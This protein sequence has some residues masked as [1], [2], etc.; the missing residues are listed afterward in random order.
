MYPRWLCSLQ[1]IDPTHC[2]LCHSKI[3]WNQLKTPPVLFT[4]NHLLLDVSCPLLPRN[5]LGLHEFLGDNTLD[6]FYHC[7]Y[8]PPL[9]GNTSGLSVATHSQPESWTHCSY[10][11]LVCVVLEFGLCK[12]HGV[13]VCWVSSVVSRLFA[14][15]WTV[16]HQ[17]P[18]SMGFSR[19][20]YWIELPCPPPGDLP[21]PRIKPMSLVSPALAEWFFI[22]STTWEAQMWVN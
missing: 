6:C 4:W 20:E 1:V 12:N 19:Q 17:A 11:A 22:T 21:D 16:A 5:I 2:T 13:H 14:T 10:T 8:Q 9:T 18:L 15:L 7:W 3:S